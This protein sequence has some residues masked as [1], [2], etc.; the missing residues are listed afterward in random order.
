MTRN[1]ADVDARLSASKRLGA[2]LLGLVFVAAAGV[3]LVIGATSGGNECHGG[4]DETVV[5]AMGVCGLLAVISALTGAGSALVAAA[6]GNRRVWGFFLPA[7][8][9]AALLVL[10]QFALADLR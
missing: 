1:I 3:W 7:L 9:I 6:T 5:L 8:A 4:C 10:A 2:A